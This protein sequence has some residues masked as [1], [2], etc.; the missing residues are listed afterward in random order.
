MCTAAKPVQPRRQ[1]FQGRCWRLLV[2]VPA[3]TPMMQ[4]VA[5]KNITGSAQRESDTVEPDAPGAQAPVDSPVG[6]AA[7]SHAD[8]TDR[9][10][11]EPAGNAPTRT[12]LQRLRP[13]ALSWLPPLLVL[14]I[15]TA[16]FGW[17]YWEPQSLFWDEN[18]HVASAY[19][20]LEGV[21]YM[22]THPPLGKMLIALGE[23]ATGANAGIDP[24]PLLQH[25][26]LAQSDLPP[27]FSF[28]GVRLAS[29]LS[30]IL[31]APLL[32]GLL[33]LATGS[34]AVALAFTCLFV[35]DNALVV[36]TRAAMLEGM[37][38]LFALATLYL[39]ARALAPG[40]RIRLWHYLGLG[41]LIG[42]A[43]AVKLNAGVLLLVPPALLLVECWPQLRERLWRPVAKRA[44]LA[45]SATTLALL[46]IFGGVFALQISLSERVID[47]RT[48]KA[49]PEFLGALALGHGAAPSTWAVGIRD[50]LRYIAEYSEGVPRL[51]VCKPGENGSPP[52]HWVLGGKTINYHWNK[53]VEN[54][55]AEVSY[56]YLLGNPLVWLP[57]LLGLVLSGSLVVARLIYGAPVHD[58]RLF[59]W[60]LLMSSLYL[61]YMLAILQIDRVMYLYH[62]LL[63]LVF[64]IVNLALVF[65][66]LFREGLAAGRLHTRLNLVGI[67]GLVLA[68]F[69]WFAPFT[70]NQPLTEQ[71]VEQRQWMSVWK[72]EPIR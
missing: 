7:G 66:Y 50:H 1:A 34:R 45:G 63:P 52:L 67:V 17:R 47:G 70:Y 59:L 25:D 51:D 21:M 27:D 48:Y 31:A 9:S 55:V 64:G 32:F 26:H 49:S 22:E 8:S 39:L 12:A 43:L 44:L 16:S 35:F 42:L 28:V 18:Y 15:A 6:R 20:Q 61:G 69:F 65:T 11:A 72:L 53:T 30:M 29:V 40:G 2:A 54:G 19:K 62:Y 37:Q 4:N 14:L 60:I 46:L 57:V 71:A 41:L 3:A 68:G 23:W 36:H 24:T 13:L 10:G 56:T 5:A 38:I 33:R 58:R